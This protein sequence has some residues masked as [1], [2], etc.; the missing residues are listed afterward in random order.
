MTRLGRLLREDDGVTEVIFPDGG[1]L[2]LEPAVSVGR[3]EGAEDRG[4]GERSGAV[5]RLVDARRGRALDVGKEGLGV[6][7]L[8]GSEGHVRWGVASEFRLGGVSARRS[9][10]V[11]GVR[12]GGRGGTKR[13]RVV[14]VVVVLGGK[15]S[16][17]RDSSGL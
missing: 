2:L 3:A 16:N 1:E 13:G 12:G 8:L 9:R 4:G 17:R 15:K 14:D 11:K 7:G 6:K 10:G 5:G